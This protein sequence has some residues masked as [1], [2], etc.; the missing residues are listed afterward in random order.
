MWKLVEYIKLNAPINA[1]RK[2]QQHAIIFTGKLL[3]DKVMLESP[4]CFVEI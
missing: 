1:G 4:L 2:K 3:H